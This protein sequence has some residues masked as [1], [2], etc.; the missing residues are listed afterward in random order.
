MDN[1]WTIAILMLL[2]VIGILILGTLA[3]TGCWI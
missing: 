3:I 2:I 1:F